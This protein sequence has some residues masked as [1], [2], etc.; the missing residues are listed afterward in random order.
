MRLKRIKYDELNGKQKEIYNFQKLTAILADYG[1]NC[2]K[3]ADDWQGADLLAYHKDGSTTL[4]VQLKSRVIISKKYRNKNLHLAFR[5][6][7]NDRWYLLMHDELLNIVKETTPW[8]QSRSWIKDGLYST[9]SPSRQMLD[10]LSDYAL[11]E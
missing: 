9:A 8:L 4:K 1:F 10:R 3:L 6:R 5:V 11:E 2:I 7:S